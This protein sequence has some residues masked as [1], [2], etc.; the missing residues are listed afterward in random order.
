MITTSLSAA[1]SVLFFSLMIS[2]GVPHKIKTGWR[3]KG[4]KW[5]FLSR[6]AI[7]DVALL[8]IY[9]WNI[10]SNVELRTSNK[11]FVGW[12]NVKKNYTNE[13]SIVSVPMAHKHTQN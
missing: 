5:W 1:L 12:N 4:Q 6:V 8:K 10:K 13:M 11:Y 2:A 3:N 9:T 7:C